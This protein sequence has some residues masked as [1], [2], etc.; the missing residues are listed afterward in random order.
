LNE[1]KLVGPGEID[2]PGLLPLGLAWN[3]VCFN[4]EI[5]RY[6]PP[7]EQRACVRQQTFSLRKYLVKLKKLLMMRDRTA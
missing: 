3:A 1:L 6:A 4:A 2:L 5:P 7:L